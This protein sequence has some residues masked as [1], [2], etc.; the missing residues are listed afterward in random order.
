MSQNNSLVGQID[1]LS[2]VGASYLNVNGQDSIV[3]PTGANPAIFVSTTK[4]GSTKAYLD[5][6]VKETSNNQFGNTHFVKTNVGKSNRERLGISR[7]DLPKYTPIIGN[8]KTFESH[9]QSQAGQQPADDDLPA[10][11]FKGF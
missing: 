5:I 7:D 6:V 1:L 3:I 4:N 10:D 11:D 2:L 9:G 8:L